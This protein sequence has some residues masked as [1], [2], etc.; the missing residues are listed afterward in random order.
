MQFE[1]LQGEKL[2]RDYSELLKKFAK[3]S[4]DFDELLSQKHEEKHS[5]ILQI[6]LENHDLKAKLLDFEEICERMDGEIAE[7]LEE[8]KK[9][10][11]FSEKNAQLTQEKTHEIQRKDQEILRKDQE[12]SDLREKLAEILAKTQEN[13]EEVARNSKE[14][15][16]EIEFLKEK[17]R[18][19][20]EKEVSQRNSEFQEVFI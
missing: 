13:T 9:I 5:E 15:A 11:A 14:M 7:K 19:D 17:L 1:R 10:K 20:A 6:E 16:Q 4:Q 12:L 2:S 3:N 8:I 18:K